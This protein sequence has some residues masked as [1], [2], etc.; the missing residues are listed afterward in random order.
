MPIAQVAAISRVGRWQGRRLSCLGVIAL[1]ACAA[2]ALS[3]RHVAHANTNP[4]DITLVQGSCVNVTDSD[5]VQLTWNPGFDASI[6]AE[7]LQSV[8]LGFSTRQAPVGRGNR[9]LETFSLTAILARQRRGA[10]GPGSTLGNGFFS[11]VFDAHITDVPPGEYLLTH[12][13][14]DLKPELAAA[15]GNSSALKNSPAGAF[16]CINVPEQAESRP[17]Q[18]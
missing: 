3:Q 11:I 9:P 12:A 17:S 10:P 14:F 5:R 4:K 2:P 18:Q 8:A 6:M 16:F 7:D 1:T 15:A 13:D